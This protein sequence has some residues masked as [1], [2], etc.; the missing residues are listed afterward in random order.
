[1]E[2]LAPAETKP[3]YKVI[4]A[5]RACGSSTL[6]TVLDLGEQYLPAWPLPFEPKPPKAPLELVACESCGLPQLKHTVDR[7][8]LFRNY[9]YRSGTTRTMRKAL[10][11]VATSAMGRVKLYDGDVVLD[12]GAND[13]TFLRQFLHCDKGITRIGFDP[14]YDPNMLPDDIWLPWI[15][16]D[17]FSAETYHRIAPQKAKLITALAMFYDLEDPNA[18]LRDVKG[19]L[20][21]DGLFVI[22]QNDLGMMLKN[23]AFDNIGFEHLCYYDTSMMAG[24][25]RNNGF[26]LHDYIFTPLNGGSHRIY[27]RHKVIDILNFG[28]TGRF[29]FTPFANKVREAYHALNQFVLHLRVQRKRIH[30]LGASTRGLTLLQTAAIADNVVFE[31]AIE[32]DPRKV[33]RMYSG[34]GIP[35]ISEGQAAEDPPDYKL[36]LPYSFLEEIQEREKEYLAKGGKLIVPLPELRIVS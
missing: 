32:R 31:A 18:F 22:Q 17:F 33:G 1:M 30:V 34:T 5:C 15:M 25:L 14:A 21:E 10:A 6:T 9:W 4:E 28:P 8:A 2:R 12:I 29:D 35:I 7:D 23:L 19:C 36:V 20:A 27:I 16:P 13:G 11:D 24:L 26:E 3:L